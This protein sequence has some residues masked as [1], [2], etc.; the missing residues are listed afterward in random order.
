MSFEE[1]S[2]RA[3]LDALVDKKCWSIIGGEDTGT[4]LSIDFGERIT[5]E[6]PLENPNLSDEQRRY[7]GELHLFITC[8]WRVEDAETVICTAQD[9]G[10]DRYRDA[11]E[12]V[13]GRKVVKTEAFAPAWDLTVEFD[14]GMRFRIFCDEAGDSD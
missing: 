12:L 7:F 1:E 14:S 6:S 8:T 4:I 13:L 3:A 9:V 5:R 2:F 10:T 11:G